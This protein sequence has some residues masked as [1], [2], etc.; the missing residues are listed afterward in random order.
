MRNKEKII[1]LHNSLRIILNIVLFCLIM[2]FIVL[3]CNRIIVWSNLSK[4]LQFLF[5]LLIGI[6]CLSIHYSFRK[7]TYIYIDSFQNKYLIDNNDLVNSN[8]RK[9]FKLSGDDYFGS[10]L[11][12][13]FTILTRSLYKNKLLKIIKEQKLNSEKY[14]IIKINR[15]LS[16][17]HI[18]VY[19]IK[20]N[21]RKYKIIVFNNL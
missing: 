3:L 8:E 13:N 7:R 21:Y 11:F 15:A 10:N 6:L 2:I 1:V 4:I 14:K 18:N 19:S 9:W 20:T 16:F 5:L 12:I 17:M